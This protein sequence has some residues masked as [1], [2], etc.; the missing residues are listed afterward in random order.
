MIFDIL[1]G[2]KIENVDVDNS[3]L[4][5]SIFVHE[6]EAQVEISGIEE[7]YINDELIEFSDELEKTIQNVDIDVIDIYKNTVSKIEI[8]TTE[9]NR[10]DIIG[11]MKIYLF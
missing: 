6:I 11:D 10:I 1:N 4:K 7:I 8:I 3:I 5:F 2:E 9:N